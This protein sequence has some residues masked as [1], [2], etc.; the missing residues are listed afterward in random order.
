MPGDLGVIYIGVLIY[1]Q[2]GVLRSAR[3]PGDLGVIYAG[4]LFYIGVLIYIGVLTLN[5]FLSYNFL[6]YFTGVPGRHTT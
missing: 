6:H 5:L 1:I 2:V 3:L 4:V